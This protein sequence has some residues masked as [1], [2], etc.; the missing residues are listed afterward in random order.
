MFQ[1][2][3]DLERFKEKKRKKNELNHRDFEVD[4]PCSERKNKQ[5]EIFIDLLL[6]SPL[7]PRQKDLEP[8]QKQACR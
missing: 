3:I 5:P 1:I 2:E 4:D 6:C 8:R 7:R